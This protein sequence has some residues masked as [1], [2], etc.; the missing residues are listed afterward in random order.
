MGTNFILS[1]KKHEIRLTFQE[2]DDDDDENAVWFQEHWRVT[3]RNGRGLYWKPRY[4]KD[5][6]T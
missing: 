5:W 3:G 1:N 4:T 2:H 6:G